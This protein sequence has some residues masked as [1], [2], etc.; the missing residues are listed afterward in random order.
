[1][2]TNQVAHHAVCLV[3][4]STVRILIENKNTQ[5]CD[6][7]ESAELWI[8]LSNPNSF[9]TLLSKASNTVRVQL[10]MVV[11]WILILIV[12]LIYCNCKWGLA[13]HSADN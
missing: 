5:E 7:R 8:A 1:M 3:K 2:P 4:D 13:F 6:A 9:L 11:K 12:H 10:K